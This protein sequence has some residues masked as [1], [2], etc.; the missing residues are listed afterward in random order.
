M[1]ISDFL[2]AFISVFFMF[3]FCYVQ[4]N[5]HSNKNRG[6]LFRDCYS[7]GIS[8]HCLH[9]AE[10]Q[11]QVRSGESFIVKKKRGSF[12]YALIGGC[13]YGMLRQA[14]YKW[15]ILCDEC[16]SHIWLSLI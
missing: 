2:G 12:R 8:Q 1:I 6:Y 14:N 5:D 4:I 16:G 9:L 13:W 3:S 15:G 7:E 11:K 10:T